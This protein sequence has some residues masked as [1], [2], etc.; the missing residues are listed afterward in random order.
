M[1]LF[2]AIVGILD[3]D[4]YIKSIQFLTCI[5]FFSAPLTDKPPKL[6]QPLENKLTIQEA[7]IGKKA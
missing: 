3:M 4:L 6:L 1:T 7:Q 2:C 5:L